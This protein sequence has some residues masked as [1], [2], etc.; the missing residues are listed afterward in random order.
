[1]TSASSLASRRKSLR[2]LETKAGSRLQKVEKG[3]DMLETCTEPPESISAHLA[4]RRVFPGTS[5]D[6]ADRATQAQDGQR[7]VASE[8]TR[9]PSG[10]QGT[11]RFSS[12]RGG[13]TSAKPATRV[14]S[15][16]NQGTLCS[17]VSSEGKEKDMEKPGLKKAK[18]LPH[19]GELGKECKI[20]GE[21]D[22]MEN[23]QE[24]S[25]QISPRRPTTAPTWLQ[26]PCG[27]ANANLNIN[28][29]AQDFLRDVIRDVMYEYQRETKSEMVDIHLDLVRMSRAWRQE[30]RQAMEEWGGE[31]KMLRQENR[32]L[33]Q[34]NERLKRLEDS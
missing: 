3:D 32:R 9:N 15:M 1:M 22:K 16:P 28:V 24:S 18:I 7:R 23:R 17:G 10:K 33:R 6:I 25:M 27:Q 4:S 13:L 5:G 26:P 14:Y 19:S 20:E 12:T 30:L 34:E 2:N 11:V 29:T 8:S 31:V 21:E